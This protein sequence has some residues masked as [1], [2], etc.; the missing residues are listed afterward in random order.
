MKRLLFCLVVTLSALFLSFNESYAQPEPNPCVNGKITYQV[1]SFYF[2][3]GGGAVVVTTLPTL[4]YA[5]SFAEIDAYISTL[6]ASAPPNTQY[7]YIVICNSTII[8]PTP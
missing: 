3:P 2:P 7:G 6:N 4:R 8:L 5:S 1:K